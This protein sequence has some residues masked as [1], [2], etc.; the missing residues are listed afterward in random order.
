MALPITGPFVQT[1]TDS[2]WEQNIRSGSRQ[3][4]PY[5]IVLPHTKRHVMIE[6]FNTND[7]TIA[8]YKAFFDQV[9]HNGYNRA[10]SDAYGRMIRQ[11]GDQAGL[12]VNIAQ[13]RQSFGMVTNRLLQLAQF[14]DALRRR[15][16]QGIARSLRISQREVKQVLRTKY[17]VARSLSDLWL[18]FWFGWKP[19]VSDIFTA[20]EVLDAPLPVSRLKGSAS[21]TT[22]GGSIDRVARFSSWHDYVNTLRVSVG[23]TVTLTCPHTRTL[24]QLGLLNPGVVAFDVIPWSFVLGWFTNINQWLSSWTDFAG[25]TVSDAYLVTRSLTSGRIIWNDYPWNSWGKQFRYHRNST[26]SVIH[27]PS[28]TLT[29]LS[30]PHTRA[31]TAISLLVQKLP[32]S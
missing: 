22:Q 28:L 13:A 6:P 23:C 9:D 17:G 30:V 24:N 21:K 10:Y 27:R 5:T 7:D 32:R 29:G 31:L 18:E 8:D 25:L 4:K 2:A 1:I 12:G 15:S 11:L 26:G 16:P 20:M 3:A 14:A 19:A